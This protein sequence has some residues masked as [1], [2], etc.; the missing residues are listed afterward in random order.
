LFRTAFG[1]G[2]KDFGMSFFRYTSIL[3]AIS[4]AIVA[5]LWIGDEFAHVKFT[6]GWLLVSALLW[7]FVSLAADRY[8]KKK[9]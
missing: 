1:A 4:A 8:L 2:S 9:R 5:A 6:G 7:M 3:C